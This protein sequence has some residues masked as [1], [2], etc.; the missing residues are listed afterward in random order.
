[1]TDTNHEE[2]K[3]DFSKGEIEMLEIHWIPDPAYGKKGP[4]LVI[5]PELDRMHLRAT[6]M[7]G[8]SDSFVRVLYGDDVC[9]YRND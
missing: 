9:D 5:T 3:V 2:E 6:G 7:Y 8:E 1:M 4:R